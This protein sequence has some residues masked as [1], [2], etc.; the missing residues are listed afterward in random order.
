MIYCKLVRFHV[1]EMNGMMFCSH[2]YTTEA[3]LLGLGNI[4]VMLVILPTYK[5]PVKA[6][7]SGCN[8][9]EID[10]SVSCG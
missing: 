9:H 6:T 8:D 1:Q 7:M 5:P 3:L 2:R 4:R 10:E